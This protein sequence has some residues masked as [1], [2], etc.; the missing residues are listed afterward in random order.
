MVYTLNA[1]IFDNGD[2]E[3]LIKWHKHLAG[4]IDMSGYETDWG[5]ALCTLLQLSK[6]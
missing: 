1:N 5:N 4:I 3:E 2:A 6:S